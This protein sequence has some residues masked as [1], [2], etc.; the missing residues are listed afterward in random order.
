MDPDRPTSSASEADASEA[1]A[2][3]RSLSLERMTTAFAKLLG[4]SSS[5]PKGSEK[6]E[7]PELHHTDGDDAPFADDPAATPKGIVEAIL[8]VGTDD[9]RGITA[10][11]LASAI[12]GV[13]EAEVEGFV[14]ELNQTYKSNHCPYRILRKDAGYVLELE[15]RFERLQQNVLGRERG[16][17]LSQAAMEILSLLAYRGELTEAEITELRG[18]PSRAILANLVRRQLL[19]V[20]LGV[21]GTDET[22]RYATAPRFLEV[23][24][25]TSLQDLPRPQE[26]AA[27]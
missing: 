8:F 23:F 1:N 12:R 7:S 14:A 19:Q 9:G 22:V 15:P 6:A 24:G 16:V 11:E 20:V 13:D 21:E 26:M 17:R 18:H 27:D 25:L 3:P 5:A 2:K 10:E 4:G